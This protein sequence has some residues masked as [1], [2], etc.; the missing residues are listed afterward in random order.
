MFKPPHFVP[1]IQTDLLTASAPPVQ[2]KLHI[3]S[4]H[5]CLFSKFSSAH[6]C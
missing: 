6:A 3:V 1:Y 4:D 2:R 5:V